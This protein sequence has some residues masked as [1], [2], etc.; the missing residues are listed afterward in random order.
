MVDDGVSGMNGGNV[1]LDGVPNDPTSI[2][3][4]W[5]RRMQYLL[6]YAKSNVLTK[7][8]VIN[9][10]SNE[11]YQKHISG[12]MYETFPTPWESNGNWSNI[13][14]KM[15]KNQSL[16]TTPQLYIFNSNSNNTGKQNDYRKV[17]FGIAS[18]LLVDNVFFGY[19]YG[20][21]NHSQLWWYDEYDAKLGKP[22]GA[23]M[24]LNGGNRF[25]SDVWRRDYSNGLALVNA[26]GES[27]VV[28]LGGEYEKIIGTQDKSVNDG[29]IVDSVFIPP[30]DGVLLYKIYQKI[31]NT[32]YPNGSFLRF[33]NLNGTRA[34]NGFFSYE[35]DLPGGS[36]IYIGDLNSD[37]LEEKIILTGNKLEIYNNNGE[38]WYSGFPFGGNYRGE[39]QIS[40][41]FLS[42]QNNKDIVVTG[43]GSAYMIVYDYHGGVLKENI[44]PFGKKY[45]GGL[46][47]AIGNFTNFRG[48]AVTSI[49]KYPSEL[50]VYDKDLNKVIKKINP[51]G[52][53]D[54]GSLA[55]ATGDF[56]GDKIDEIAIVRQQK[57]PEVKIYD[58]NLKK[59]GGFKITGIFG[60]QKI[61]LSSVTFGDDKK[62]VLMV[63]NKN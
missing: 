38:R 20:D 46:S 48:L 10:S 5:T 25:Q 1:T 37:S 31:S 29:S 62:H 26:T 43:S 3:A 8:I 11:A 61:A 55:V 16:N 59:I 33:Y 41:G 6:S 57:T 63:A 2:D 30:K 42:N 52:K 34:R 32:T 44:Y 60:N 23:A 12:R 40:V 24:S 36:K 7:Y 50:V 28:D 27:K 4:E 22:S 45:R 15:L 53:Q 47:A 58:R 49:G 51:W 21:Q 13:M 14:T 56:N 35:S 39:I 19:D 9:G 17:R 54:K 18:S